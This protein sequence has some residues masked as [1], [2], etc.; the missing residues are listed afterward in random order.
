MKHSVANP[1]WGNKS[2]S[3]M[4]QSDTQHDEGYESDTKHEGYGSDTK[5]GGC[6][7]D[8]KHIEAE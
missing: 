6:E 7:S 8:T 4:G 3:K 1:K 5:H 2:L